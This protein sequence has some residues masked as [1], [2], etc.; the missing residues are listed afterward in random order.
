MYSFS[1]EKMSVVSTFRIC[2]YWF[3]AGVTHA[4]CECAHLHG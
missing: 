2:L 1:V 3:D 4:F